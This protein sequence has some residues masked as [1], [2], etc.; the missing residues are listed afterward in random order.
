[1]P[2]G[3][4]ALGQVVVVRA[5]PGVGVGLRLGEDLA[6]RAL[7]PGEVRLRAGDGLVGLGLRVG[8]QRGGV[9][10]GPVEQLLRGGAGTGVAGLDLGQQGRDLGLGVAAVGGRVLLG[11]PA[12]PVEVGDG[13]VMQLGELGRVCLVLQA[14]PLLVCPLLLGQ[15]R[16]RALVLDARPLEQLVGAGL[17]VDQARLSLLLG[18]RDGLVTGLGGAG[19]QQRGLVG[20]VGEHDLDLGAGL[21]EAPFGLLARRE[22]RGLQLLQLVG[23]LLGL[24]TDP[25]GLGPGLGHLT[26]G[27]RPQL[28]GEVLGAGE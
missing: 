1:M 27:V 23:R 20:R 24:A 5:G 11:L 17:G 6:D 4:R 7:R 22:H 9:G 12:L 26:V 10:A 28:V 18:Q 21:G 3:A 19:P 16:H 15:A 8:E 13:G 14:P 2:V 25:G